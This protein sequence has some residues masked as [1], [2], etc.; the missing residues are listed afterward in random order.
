MVAATVYRSVGAKQFQALFDVIPFEF[1]LDSTSLADEANL[2]IIVTGVTGA[3]LGD[4]VIGSCLTTLDGMTLTFDVDAADTVSV[5]IVNKSGSAADTG[6][7]TGY[8][9]VLVRKTNG[10][11]AA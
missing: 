2:E 3:N 7:T 5:N 10:P 11:W 4:F 8:G 6:A 1:A 9:L